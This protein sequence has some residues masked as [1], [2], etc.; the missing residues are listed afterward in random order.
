MVDNMSLRRGVAA[1]LETVG[2]G[3]MRPNILLM[4]YKNDWQTC[5][6][7]ALEQ[8]FGAVQ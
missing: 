8:Y 6:R 5:D 3:K 2:V 7:D 1:L 4:G